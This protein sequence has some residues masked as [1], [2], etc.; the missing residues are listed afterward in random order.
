MPSPDTDRGRARDRGL[1]SLRRATAWS[2]AGVVGAS[3]MA[4]LALGVSVPGRTATTS[5]GGTATT[6]T[7]TGATA[8]TGSTGTGS[9]GTTG[10]TGSTPVASSPVASSTPS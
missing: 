8:T 2:A 3:A 6:H 4:A 5:S 1:S 9:T 10:T 7:T